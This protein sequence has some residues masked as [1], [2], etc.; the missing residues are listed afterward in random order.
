MFLV[1][2]RFCWT[3][4]TE[5]N[6][7]RIWKWTYPTEIYKG[8]TITDSFN[9]KGAWFLMDLKNVWALI[10]KTFN[11]YQILI[12][13]YFLIHLYIIS[14]CYRSFFSDFESIYVCNISFITFRIYMGRKLREKKLKSF[15]GYLLGVI[16]K[17]YNLKVSCF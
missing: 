9:T 5:I 17:N 4:G 6:L 13:C 11:E 14:N 15:K 16:G 7:Y 3:L 12:G 8:S 10:S 2:L 1:I